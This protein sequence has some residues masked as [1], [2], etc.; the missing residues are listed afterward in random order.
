MSKTNY[1][2]LCIISRGRKGSIGKSKEVHNL[3]NVLKGNI[4]NKSHPSEIIHENLIGNLD[5]LGL[6]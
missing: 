4:R 5:R 6:Y 2:K 3:Q 1:S